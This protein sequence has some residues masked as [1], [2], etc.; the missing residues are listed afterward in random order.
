MDY[1]K[2]HQ[3]EP[4]PVQNALDPHFYFESAGHAQARMRLERGVSQRRG[5][6]SLVGAPGC[7]KSTLAH[8]LSHAL[9]PARYLQQLRVISHSACASGWLL[10]HVAEA[11]G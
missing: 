7:G 6:L 9:D 4:E 11:F 2:F 3:L 10:P 8:H 1:L 5:L